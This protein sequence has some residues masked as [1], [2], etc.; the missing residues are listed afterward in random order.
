[1]AV[2]PEQPAAS[3]F[4]VQLIRDARAMMLGTPHVLARYLRATDRGGHGDKAEDAAPVVRVQIGMGTV[5]ATR[6]RFGPEFGRRH[7]GGGGVGQDGS[8]RRCV[9]WALRARP[10]VASIG[11]VLAAD[12]GVSVADGDGVS[13]IQQLGERDVLVVPGIAVGSSQAEVRLRIVSVTGVDDGSFRA[14]ATW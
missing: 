9:V 8:S 2:V 7:P 1:M 13:F 3:D 6:P 12:G 10:D 4:A 11:D 14:E 5:P